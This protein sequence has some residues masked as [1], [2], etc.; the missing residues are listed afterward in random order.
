M[1]I[2]ITF[3]MSV[4][5]TWFSHTEWD[6]DMVKSYVCALA[7]EFHYQ[8][9]IIEKYLIL[10]LCPEGFLWMKWEEKQLT[11]NCQTNIAGPGFHGAVIHF[12]ELI[13]ARKK[14]RLS[15]N[16]P[17]GYFTDRDFKT[18]RKDYFYRWFEQMINKVVE[19]SGDEKEQLVCWPLNYYL[20]QEYK[21]T[22]MTHIRRFSYRELKGMIHS[23]LSM[24]FARDFFVWNEE[25]KD[26]YY[27]RNCA[28]VILHQ[29]CYFM[30]SKRSSE[31]QRLN[32]KIIKLLEQALEQDNRIPF[33]VEVYLEVCKLAEHLPVDLNEVTP[34]QVD[35]PIGCRKDFVYRTIGKIR[36][37]LPGH[38]LYESTAARNSEKYYD[39]KESGWHEFYIC[40]ISMKEQAQL[41]EQAFQKADIKQVITAEFGKA[42]GKIAVYSPKVRDKIMVY[43]IS[44]QLVY[45]NQL[46]IVSISFTDENDQPE[47]I[48]LIKKIQPID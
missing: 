1:S 48:N 20:P 41:Q 33:P 36:F 3:S 4:P 15:L 45:E 16:D 26:A 46:T 5:K 24:V 28:L 10:Q 12:L 23:G 42:V 18:L 35:F 2:N 37:A 17:T 43:T 38:Y 13:A 44:A 14:F 19:Q 8:C 32:E 25:E 34:M 21:N 31:D 47:M 29:E 40:A 30:P 27:Y 7:E 22:V 39:G 11:G 6:W 9:D